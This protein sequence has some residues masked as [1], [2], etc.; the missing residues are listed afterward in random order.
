MATSKAKSAFAKYIADEPAPIE[1]LPQAISPEVR[2]LLDWLQH[3]WRKETVCGR[4]LYRHFA[5]E[6]A[7][8]LKLAE[9][10]ER[11]GWLLPLRSHR[12]DRK[13]WQVTIGPLG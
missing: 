6:K 1:P 4:D 9:T 10:L 5:G 13:R 12:Y 11:F 3:T 7:K 8:A 2:Q